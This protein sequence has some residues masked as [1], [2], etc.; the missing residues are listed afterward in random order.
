MLI[1]IRLTLASLLYDEIIQ[2]LLH[3]AEVVLLELK[4]VLF[5][6]FFPPQLCSLIVLFDSI[7]II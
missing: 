1:F 3:I 7:Y 2:L 4:M 5:L 6:G